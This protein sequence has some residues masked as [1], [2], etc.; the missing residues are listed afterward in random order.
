MRYLLVG[1][2]N[3]GRKRQAILG[4]RCVATV[5]PF[6]PVAD[7]PKPDR[8]PPSQYDAV[9]LAVP[10]Q[11]KLELLQHF[12]ESG[13]HVL[14]EKPL[15]FPDR[16]TAD[17][18]RA[19][20]ESH[21]AIWYTSYNHRFEPHIAELHT[22]LLR[23]SIGRIYHG[24]LLYGNGTVANV[25]NSWR[26]AGLGVLED[27]GSH[28]LDLAGELLGCRGQRFRA[29]SLERHE[30]TAYDHAIIATHDGRFVLEASFLA[31][32]NTFSVDVFGSAGSLHINGLPKWGPA[33]F[34]HRVRVMP[35]G[36]PIENVQT[37]EA[38]LDRTWHADLAHFEAQVTA[39]ETSFDND[40]WIS[41][42]LKEIGSESR[43][44]T[45]QRAPMESILTVSA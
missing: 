33:S 7:Y 11:D 34:V 31:W 21:R 1:L 24:R 22:E 28:L 37:I 10:N 44:E 30:A 43:A 13:K 25:A 14:V 15:L 23:G 6:N 45:E 26:D 35:S 40:W 8:C 29:L 12:L 27:L 41:R 5:D 17:R 39:G 42:T 20:A 3:I 32:K 4:D 19:L 38:G 2:G 18:I 36:V 9:V 16:A